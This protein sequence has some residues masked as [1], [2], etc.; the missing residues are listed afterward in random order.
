[1]VGPAVNGYHITLDP[2]DTVH[3]TKLNILRIKNRTLFNMQLKE[4]SDLGCV[5]F[6]F[7]DLLRIKPVFFH[8]IID[9]NAVG[10]C[11]ILAVFNIPVAKHRT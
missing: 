3:K 5:P 11:E 9:G 2:D 1:M 4:L 8:G 7:F 10:I 6:R